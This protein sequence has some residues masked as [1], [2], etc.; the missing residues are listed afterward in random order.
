MVASLLAIGVEQGFAGL[1]MKNVVKLPNEIGAIA[2]T[3]AHA[4]PDK[5]R[6]LMRRV[7]GEEDSA[8]PPF[9]GDQRVKTVAGRPPQR[10]VV[11]REPLREELP[12]L[13]P[14]SA[15]PADLRQAAA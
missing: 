10:G 7:A 6:L 9:P 4:L 14:V 13:V 12:D 8:A 3:L 15:P 5:G 2:Q 1:P 11:R